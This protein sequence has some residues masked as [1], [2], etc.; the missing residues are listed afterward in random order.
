MGHELKNQLRQ[1][2]KGTTK[3]MGLVK[4]NWKNQV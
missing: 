2:S 3:I 1:G 4:I